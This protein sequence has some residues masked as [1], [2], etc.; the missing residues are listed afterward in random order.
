MCR[1]CWMSF[2]YT[3]IIYA[4][5]WKNFLKNESD[6]TFSSGSTDLF[7]MLCFSMHMP[8]LWSNVFPLVHSWKTAAPSSPSHEQNPSVFVF[9]ANGSNSARLLHSRGSQIAT[10]TLISSTQAPSSVSN[11][12]PNVQWLNVGITSHEQKPLLVFLAANGSNWE[13]TRHCIGSQASTTQDFR[14]SS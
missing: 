4:S 5:F 14:L 3:G 7:S 12:C 11:T 8:K 13:R 2:G 6:L 9:D 1:M 10:W